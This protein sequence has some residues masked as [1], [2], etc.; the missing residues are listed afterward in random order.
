[1]ADHTLGA[2]VTGHR[3]RARTAVLEQE[4]RWLMG[5]FAPRE[6]LDGIGDYLHRAA[7]EREEELM[8]AI[9]ARAAELAEQDADLPVD[10]PSRGMLAL[11]S[12]VLAAFETLLPLFDGDRVRTIR[13]LQ[14]VFGAMLRRTVDAAFGALA[15]REDPLGA[16]D[17]ACR[18][19]FAMYGDYYE[20]TFERT[21][22]TFEMR[23]GR[24]F[25]RDFFDRHDARP[26]TT[27]LCAWDANWMTALDPAL[28]G[29]VSERTS[30]LSLG[31]DACR[32]R[33][34]RTD[35]PLARHS[36]ALDRFGDE[37][38]PAP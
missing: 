30:L 38:A 34:H 7:P 14:R 6:L 21:D 18:A 9:R 35:D 8:A 26:V 27:V 12:V 28:G 23:I 24:C 16:V 22:G 33:V 4:G 5:R 3:D 1:M 25:F 32:F 36:D 13:Y 2:R 29:L 19:D 11:S 15:R 10:G 31:D 17:D 20:T 37:P